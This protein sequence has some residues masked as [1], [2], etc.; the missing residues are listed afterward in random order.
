MNFDEFVTAAIKHL[1]S[2]D[3]T[4]IQETVKY[5]VKAPPQ[6]ST[7]LRQILMNDEWVRHQISLYNK[8]S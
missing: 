3:L 6:T 7:R 5:I 4:G 1:K 2:L 8:D